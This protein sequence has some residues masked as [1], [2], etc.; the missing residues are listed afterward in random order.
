MSPPQSHIDKI[1]IKT[2]SSTKRSS[3][4]G[5]F[6]DDEDR[7]KGSGITSWAESPTSQSQSGLISEKN[8]GTP[9]FSI[10][11]TS[12]GSPFSPIYNLPEIEFHPTPL[13]KGRENSPKTTEFGPEFCYS[14][15]MDTMDSQETLGVRTSGK[16]FEK[17]SE[18]NDIFKNFL[19]KLRISQMDLDSEFSEYSDIGV[20]YDNP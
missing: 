17:S 12:M 4:Y 14:E 18:N 6:D 19:K 20:V 2:A 9:P 16:K 10:R 3:R 7:D 8:E 11:Y 15:N 13:M 5:L 1:G